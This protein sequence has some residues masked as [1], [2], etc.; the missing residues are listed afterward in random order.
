MVLRV[1]PTV[2]A[3]VLVVLGV[4]VQRIARRL[5][6]AIVCRS[7]RRG[8]VGLV[9]A[10]FARH[11]EDVDVALP[12]FDRV[13]DRLLVV[14]VVGECCDA[15]PF[16]F[17]LFGCFGDAFDLPLC[18]ADRCERFCGVGLCGCPYLGGVWCFV[19]WVVAC[20]YSGWGCECPRVE[21]GGYLGFCLFAAD[22]CGGG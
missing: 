7:G 22:L 21:C 20:D 2:C 3:G 4:G 18:E 14:C 12:C 13:D 15:V 16:G 17:T 8:F 6:R 19:L 9:G 11:G 1:S 5:G 10:G